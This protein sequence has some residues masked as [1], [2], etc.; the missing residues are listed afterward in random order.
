[1]SY[2]NVEDIQVLE[3]GTLVILPSIYGESVNMF[4]P[5]TG[6]LIQ[7]YSLIAPV[8]VSNQDLIG[9]AR[10]SRSYSVWIRVEERQQVMSMMQYLIIH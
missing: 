5:S 4:N 7:D 10:I 8:A 9:I 2:P 3:D 6:E 1:M